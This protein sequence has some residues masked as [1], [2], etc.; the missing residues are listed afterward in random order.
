MY[1]IIANYC[2]ALHSADA[3]PKLVC[4]TIICG[5]ALSRISNY[6]MYE[7]TCCL[8]AIMHALP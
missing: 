4:N 1:G 7:P 6:N 3:D 5:Y 2:L 8:H